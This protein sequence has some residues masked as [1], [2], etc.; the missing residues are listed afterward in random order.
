MAARPRLRKRAHFPPNLHEPRPGYFTW[1]NPV[2][3]KT[4]VIGR[5]PLAHAIQEANEANARAEAVT[6]RK[7]LTERIDIGKETVGD[8]LDKMP[9][10]GLKP[11]TLSM[12]R[13]YDRRIRAAIGAIECHALTTKDIA[14]MVDAVK[15]KGTMRTA[16][17]LRSR[18]SEVCN[19]GIALGWMEKNPAAVTEKV[20]VKVKRRRL[21]LEEFQATLEKA[22]AVAEW[23]ENAMLLAIVSGQ[24]RSTIGRWERSAVKGETILAKRS[25]TEVHIA[26]PI[27]LHLDAIGI[28]LAD[29]IGRCKSTGV[30]S[31]Y[32]IH[33]IRPVGTVKRGDPVALETITAAF[34]EARELARITGND[35]PTF[36]E[37]RSLSKR[38]Y[39][40]QGGVD[41]RALL[42]HLTESMSNL[43]ANTRGLEPIQVK[44]SAA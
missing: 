4:H 30:V 26:I 40:Q 28:S 42:G 32:L 22:P 7:S 24:D 39:M 31:R 35:A 44:I 17:A 12:Q 34:R 21:T 10:E 13:S 27:A 37:I 3:G 33:H 5:I 43:Y 1:R 23:L 19:K 41:T 15:D 11:N 2:D 6:Q 8:L 36:H 20:K 38:L 14:A 18:I 29:V 9:T 25:K 16:Q